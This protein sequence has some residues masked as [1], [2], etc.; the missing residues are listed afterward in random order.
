MVGSQ[1]WLECIS[2][3][4]IGS[5]FIM[6]Q[7]RSVSQGW[8]APRCRPA[9]SGD[10]APSTPSAGMPRQGL[11]PNQKDIK[12]PR[13]QR[14]FEVDASHDIGLPKTSARL[15]PTICPGAYLK[16]LLRFPSMRRTETSRFCSVTK[17]YFQHITAWFLLFSS[18]S[19]DSLRILGNSWLWQDEPEPMP[20]AEPESAGR[21]KI[22]DHLLFLSEL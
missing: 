6:D 8:S 21:E 1:L 20:E 17:D 2:L 13:Q 5:N 4:H 14:E 15:P 3:D 11:I 18:S 7:F 16:P 19:S 9:C 10:S 22:K 12:G